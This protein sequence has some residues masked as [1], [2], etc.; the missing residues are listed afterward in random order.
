MT[1]WQLAVFLAGAALPSFFVSLG[2]T[3]L[4]RR[5][6]PGWG[7][8]DR[9]AA[10]KVHVTPT[11]LGGGIAIWL[12]TV[13]PLAVGLLALALIQQGVVPRDLV[14]DFAAPHLAG[15]W[16]QSGKLLGLVG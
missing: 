13:L 3:A 11:P 10:R 7:L 14:P 8:I 5:L 6:A 15:I 2:V 16:Q 1:F 4:V 9:P 12:A